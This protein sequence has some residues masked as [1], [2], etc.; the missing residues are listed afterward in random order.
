MKMQGRYICFSAFREGKSLKSLRKCKICGSRSPPEA[1]FCM[2]CGR[3]LEQIAEQTDTRLPGG[4]NYLMVSLAISLLVSLI[5][6]KLTGMPILLVAG[7][8]PLLL[9]KR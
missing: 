7:F 2:H 4:S 8:L 5:L 9:R 6:M 3:P 1:A